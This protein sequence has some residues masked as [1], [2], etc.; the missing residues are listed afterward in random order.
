[1]KSGCLL[2]ILGFVI[3]AIVGFVI[4]PPKN[5]TMSAA[6]REAYMNGCTGVAQDQEVYCECTM[7]YLDTTYTN[8]QILEMAEKFSV[9][10]APMPKEM[11]NA[12][13]ACIYLVK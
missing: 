7:T 8:D 2:I 3:A 5:D 13:N 9:D 1:M 10:N 4:S 11:T 12:V 6:W